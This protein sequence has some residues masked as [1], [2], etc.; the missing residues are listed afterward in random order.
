MKNIEINEVYTLFEEIKG[1]IKKGSNNV[2]TIVQPEIEL[3]DLSVI[4]ELTD[5]LQ[6]TI[7]EIRKPVKTECHHTFSGNVINQLKTLF[8]YVPFL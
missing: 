7:E 4:S 3:P 2:P 6:E 8:P 5:K 1:L